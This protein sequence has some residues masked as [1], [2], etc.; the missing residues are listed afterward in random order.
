[1]SD[2]SAAADAAVY[3]GHAPVRAGILVTGTEVLTAVI[4][5]RNGPWLS[6]RLNEIGV[7]VAMIEVVGDRPDDLRRALRAMADAGL[8]LIV[9]SGGLGPTADDLTAPLVGEFS[10]REMVLDAAL[11]ERIAEIVRAAL[12][13]RSG[14]DADALAL[15]NRKQ[16][17][18][19]DGAAVLAPQGTAPGLVVPPA[20]AGQPTV[21]VLPGPPSELQPMWEDAVATAE[22]KRAT[23]G[24]LV[25]AQ[26]TLR[27][28]GL[29]EAQIADTLR[30]A[31]DAGIDLRRLEITTCLRRGE[32]EITT[33]FPP[34]ARAD[35]DALRLLIER[36]HGDALFSGDGAT[37]DQQVAELLIA[38]EDTV[39]LAESCTGG[40][41]AARLTD[42]PGASAYV[43][44]GVVVYSDRAKSD[45]VDVD[46][47]LIAERG[48]VSIEVAQALAA[49]ARRRFATSVGVGVTGVA[50]PGGGSERK[51]VGYVCLC[52]V[53][54]TPGA[55][56]A[57]RSITRA[58][59][60]P[61]D[62]AAIR[63]RAT[64]VAMHMIADVL[65]G[66]SD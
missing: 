19:P 16:A 54:G 63:D 20:V 39:A 1:M 4:P 29:P 30:A 22:F 15:A 56:T 60:L 41:L 7:D 3:T 57:L 52:V 9:T 14:A 42:R 37:I 13:R 6:E 8:S 44:G 65:R 11:E 31:G 18:V 45:L 24:A 35:Y 5:D 55:E 21:V 26:A 38:G 48:A 62:R 2:P 25:R 51:P 49:G 59:N 40:L 36:R 64:T 28:F 47:A 50:G 43:I 34:A 58:V 61:G 66:E 33:R 46:P 10:G 12:G 53:F 27:L 23:A 32:L 17:L